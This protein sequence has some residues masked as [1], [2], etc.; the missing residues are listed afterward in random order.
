MAEDMEPVG[1]HLDITV[2]AVAVYFT[3]LLLK[4]IPKRERTLNILNPL[5]WPLYSKV[6]TYPCYEIFINFCMA[7]NSSGLFFTTVYIDSRV[8]S[9]AQEITP[10]LFEVANYA[11]SFQAVIT[12]NS[13]LI[14]SLPL[15]SSSAI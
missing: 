6:F 13:S 1:L 7:W 14:I 5:L 8:S 4:P 9:L 15:I 11:F 12:P 3:G 2:V 10:V